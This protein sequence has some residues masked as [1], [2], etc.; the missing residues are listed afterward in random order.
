MNRRSR[1]VV[2]L[3]GVGSLIALGLVACG[4]ERTITVVPG[5]D[6]RDGQQVVVTLEDFPPNADVYV[7]QCTASGEPS[8]GMGGGC[9]QGVTV[10][11]NAEGSA[12]ATLKLKQRFA[13]STIE[14]V[15]YM[16]DCAY[17]G[18]CA[19]AAG[20]AQRSDWPR[21]AFAGEVVPVAAVTPTSDLNSIHADL[22][23]SGS[24]VPPGATI[25][26]SV[27]L[28]GSD[29][30]CGY[31][32]MTTAT[33]SG[34]YAHALA[35]GENL[36][37]ATCDA[38]GQCELRTRVNASLVIGRAPLSFK[39]GPAAYVTPTSG[40]H[41]TQPSELTARGVHVSPDASVEFFQCLTGG[42]LSACE[43]RGATRADA[44][45]MYI[46]SELTVSRVFSKGVCDAPDKC[47]LVTRVNGELIIA[48]APLSFEQPPTVSVTPSSQLN[49]IQDVSVSLSG[50][51]AGQGFEL[52]QCLTGTNPY[53]DRIATGSG[54]TNGAH[55]T[56]VTVRQTLPVRT[57]GCDAPGQ[58]TVS[59]WLNG[60]G[61]VSSAPLTFK[62]VGP[63]VAGNIAAPA[64]V[65][66]GQPLQLLGTG[67]ASNTAVT[68]SWCGFGRYCTEGNLLANAAGAFSSTSPARA[69][70]AAPG[71][72]LSFPVSHYTELYDCTAAPNNCALSARDFRFGSASLPVPISIQSASVPSGSIVVETAPRL[73]NPFLAASPIT[74]RGSGWSPNRGLELYQCA[75][76]S[77]LGSALL[78][79]QLTPVTTDGSGAFRVTRDV[80]MGALHMEPMYSTSCEAPGSC[81]LVLADSRL[82]LSSAGRVPLVFQ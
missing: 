31:G 79:I 22:N 60:L 24:A 8:V 63:S 64:I 72:P 10:R 57:Q 80:F 36:G 46:S 49:A 52:Y 76:S 12:R 27:C 16:A 33:G 21:L 67:W 38:P 75:S 9:V 59:V 82:A 43:S 13:Y 18:Y 81:S 5:S 74:L 37:N 53:C 66:A 34:T 26:F 32:S 58:C 28:K 25:D 1:R 68:V 40:L 30:S 6:L 55:S 2:V 4:P 71:I 70:L 69:F 20:D 51:A 41:M 35:V 14:G 42:S 39:A 7:R 47:V 45:G 65:V 17:R 78:C 48:D 61:V 73:P 11:T 19:V 29:S 44:L 23:A 62:P 3:G 56:T 77:P 54:P 50:L 15:Q